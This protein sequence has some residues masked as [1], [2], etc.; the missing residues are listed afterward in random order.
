MLAGS[1]KAV[2]ALVNVNVTSEVQV[3]TIPLSQNRKPGKVCD[4]F[5][6]EW[7]LPARLEIHIPRLVTE[8]DNPRHLKRGV[9]Q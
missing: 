6:L 9:E 2:E 4:E 8:H 3:D 7:M 5:G 1:K